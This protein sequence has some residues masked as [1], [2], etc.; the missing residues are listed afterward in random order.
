LVAPLFELTKRDVGFVWNL[1]C[2]QA[3]EA[4]KRTPIAIPTL[5]HPDFKKPLC[6][7]VDWSPKG[8]GDILLQKEG[9]LERLAA[10]AKKSLTST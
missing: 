3:F 2:Q 9:K 8:V 1:D 7:D 5:V 6:L 4:L 10:Y